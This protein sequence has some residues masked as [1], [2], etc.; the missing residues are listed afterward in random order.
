MQLSNGFPED[1]RNLIFDLGN[2]LVDI[3]ISATL[4]AFA[5]LNIGGLRPEDIHPHQNG[6]FL[7]YELGHLTD[8]GFLS[9]IRR[10]YGCSGIPDHRIWEAWNAMIPAVDSG[11]FRL[12]KGLGQYRLFVLSNTNPQHISRLHGLYREATGGDDFE[13]FFEACFYSHDMHLR[14]PDPEIYRSVINQTGIIPEQTLFIDDN[15]CNFPGARALELKTYHLT[16]NETLF[17]LFE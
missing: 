15:A 16:G 12:M 1:I 2:V 3:D 11:R 14:K 8:D 6:F 4:E 5:A 13:R 7:D 17:G 10:A 9:A